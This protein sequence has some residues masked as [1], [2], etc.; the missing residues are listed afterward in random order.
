[1]RTNA[2]LKPGQH[3][4]ITGGSSGLGY[5]LADEFLKRGLRVT[6]VA[7][8]VDQLETAAAAL[9]RRHP[10]GSV[11]FASLDVT[12]HATVAAWFDSLSPADQPDVLVNS[13]GILREGRFEELSLKDFSEVWEVN[14]LAAIATT[15]AALPALLARK[16]RI[17]NIA[18]VAGLL[19]V[20]GYSS[21]SAS[22]HGL[23]GFT[24]SLRF[25]LEP[26]GVRVQMVC[27]GEFESPM[28]DAL[29]EGRTPENKAQAQTIPP[30]S[31]EGVARDAA[32]GI[33][34]G[35]PMIIPGRLA[36]LVVLG[37]RLAPSV[38]AAVSRRA[39]A[40]ARA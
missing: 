23:V 40:R 8:R 9:R 37:D 33:E 22:K 29:N 10:S 32:K 34:R 21:Y 38:S 5:A 17:I 3:A 20:F 18:S 39:I 12:D 24:N 28:V 30:R 11:S 31:V 15:R 36:S 14:V 1:M 13:A 25:E 2:P 16:G 27:P 19:G 35:R 4:I 6:L 26:Q 7:R